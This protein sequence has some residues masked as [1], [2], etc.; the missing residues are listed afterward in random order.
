VQSAF[1]RHQFYR[2]VAT[3]AFLGGGSENFIQIKTMR[4][5]PDCEF[6]DMALMRASILGSRFPVP[7]SLFPRG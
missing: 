6:F 2:A 7:G 4:L 5:T 1:R 3:P